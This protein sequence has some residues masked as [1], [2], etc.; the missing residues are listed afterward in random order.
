MSTPGWSCSPAWPTWRGV[1]AYEVFL[2]LNGGTLGK[3][4]DLG[5][6]RQGGRVAP[7]H[8]RRGDADGPLHRPRRCSA[9]SPAWSA[10]TASSS[11][12]SSWWHWPVLIMLFTDG[13]RQTP[14]DK[15]GKT[16]VV[17][18]QLRSG[19]SP[20]AISQRR[21][22][23]PRPAGRRRRHVDVADPEVG[24]GVDHRVV[25]RRGGPDRARLPDAL[26]P[27][28]LRG[29]GVSR[30]IRSKLGSSAAEAKP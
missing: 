27:S 15:V 24:Q 20:R 23:P 30:G 21:R 6:H 14:W 25:D 17:A 7:R 9:S 13:R 1:V 10:A 28:G 5:P 12:C 16:L 4:A 19:R 26:G 11:S 22:W 3:R 18:S 29:V 2:N 8:E